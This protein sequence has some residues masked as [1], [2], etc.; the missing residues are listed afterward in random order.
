MNTIKS[1]ALA[2]LA[3]AAPLAAAQNKINLGYTAVTDFTAAFVAKEEGYFKKR[4]LDVDMQ[5]L[6]ITSA[7]P[8]AL[9]SDSIQVGGTVPTVLLQAVDSGLDLVAFANASINDNT[10]KNPA[11]LA[12]TGSNI[13]SAQDL[14]GKKVGVPGVG[15]VMHV[16]IRRWIMEKGVDPKKVTYIETA[17][18]QMSDLLKAGTIDAVATADPFS[19]RIEQAGT[20]A[21]V[22]Y[23]GRD[24]PSGFS[25]VLYAANRGWAAQNP[26]QVQAFREALVEAIAF[27][28]KEPQKTRAHI[29]K[30][31]K[32]PAPVLETL[33]IPKMM[34]D[35]AAP[36]LRFWAESMRQQGMLKNEPNLSA[37]IVK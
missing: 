9:Q 15:G 5:L 23:V 17:F 30:Y 4:G 10:G 11:L 24:F 31:I 22:S 14:V 18:P 25:N 33:P 6:T 20:G 34:A 35:L 27:V 28:E 1:L 7:I 26:A 19:T 32:L 37:V 3:L 13:K 21:V 2:A 8:A 36:R 16:L 29:G 12:R